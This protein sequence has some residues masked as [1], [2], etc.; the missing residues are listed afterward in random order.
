MDAGFN[1]IARRDID[2]GLDKK[3]AYYSYVLSE[4]MKAAAK[5]GA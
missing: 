2:L 5:S 4:I 1:S 3:Y